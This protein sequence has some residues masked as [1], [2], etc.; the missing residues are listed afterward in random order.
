MSPAKKL[1]AATAAAAGLA[2]ASSASALVVNWTAEFENGFAAGASFN[3]F[4]AAVSEVPGSATTVGPAALPAFSQIRWPGAAGPSGLNVTP[5]SIGGGPVPVV[6]NQPHADTV[7]I[8]HLN[9]VIPC[10]PG[11]RG[12]SDGTPNPGGAICLNALRDTVLLT[13]LTLT[14]LN[15]DGMGTNVVINDIVPLPVIPIGIR[16]AETFNQDTAAECGFAEALGGDPCRDIFVIL[17]PEDLVISL[18][19]NFLGDGET[20]FVEIGVEGLDLLSDEACARAGVGPDCVGL[21]TDEGG[22]RSVNANIRIFTENQVP[23]PGTL[24]ILALGLLALG[25]VTRRKRV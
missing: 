1:V 15:V 25:V 7:Q 8:T 6:V 11:V 24:A 2:F 12:N 14:A 10:G 23:E 13:H 19:V 18:P 9:E 20:Y 3:W 17:N 16:F 21:T 4:G 5:D 22:T